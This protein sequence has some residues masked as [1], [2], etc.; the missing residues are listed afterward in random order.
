[1]TNKVVELKSKTKQQKEEAL[2]AVKFAMEAEEPYVFISGNGDRVIDGRV[3][4]LIWMVEKF[5]LE[6]LAGSMAH[7]QEE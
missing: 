6:L 2:A 1:M 4:D 7:L 5:K 3:G